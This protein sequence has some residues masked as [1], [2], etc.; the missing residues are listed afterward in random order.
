LDDEFEDKKKKH[1]M[2]K[3]KIEIKRK[4]IKLKEK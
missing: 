1:K 2:F 3:K 4:R